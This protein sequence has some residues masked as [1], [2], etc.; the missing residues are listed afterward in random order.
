[1]A[2]KPVHA[3]PLF[4]KNASRPVHA[5]SLQSPKAVWRHGR[6]MLLRV[7]HV[8]EDGLVLVPGMHH[9]FYV[10][11]KNSAECFTLLVKLLGQLNFFWVQCL[12][13]KHPLGMRKHAENVS[14]PAAT[15]QDANKY[16]DR[17]IYYKLQTRCG[18]LCVCKF[19]SYRT[20]LGMHGACTC[21]YQ[22]SETQRDT[23]TH[24][25]LLHMQIYIYIVDMH[26]QTLFID[27]YVLVQTY[28]YVYIY[29]QRHVY[30]YIYIHTRI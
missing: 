12:A 8:L 21:T 5:S 9:I 17:A 27:V 25:I 30:T 2:S 6:N 23:H 18:S 19:K 26:I 24:T 14:F 1:M 16:T 7:H 13:C 22:C 15:N 28:T 11:S 10:A 20:A 4:P 3:A 29:I